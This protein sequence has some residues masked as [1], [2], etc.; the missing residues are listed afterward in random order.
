MKGDVHTNM[1]EGC[2]SILKRGI[3]GIYQHVSKKHL[4][5]YLQ[6]FDF[7]YNTRKTDDATR[8]VMALSCIEG[9]RLMYQDPSKTL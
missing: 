3:N 9:K 7:R 8:T 5:R 1:I 6:E 4:Q 2:F